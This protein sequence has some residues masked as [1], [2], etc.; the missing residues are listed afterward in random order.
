[1]GWVL[2]AIGI[3]GLGIGAVVLLYYWPFPVPF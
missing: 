1:M 3:G 2:A